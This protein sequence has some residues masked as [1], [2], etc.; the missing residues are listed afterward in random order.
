MDTQE[1]RRR[2]RNLGGFLALVEHEIHALSDQQVLSLRNKYSRVYQDMLNPP[3]LSPVICELNKS[4]LNNLH[5]NLLKDPSSYNPPCSEE[6]LTSPMASACR[7]QYPHVH[8]HRIHMKTYGLIDCLE[9][10]QS[11]TSM[12]P[13]ETG[14][15][16]KVVDLIVQYKEHSEWVTFLVTSIGQ[17]TIILGHMWLMEL[18][19]RNRLVHGRDQ[20]DW[21]A[22]YC[23]GQKPQ[24]REIGQ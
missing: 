23:A 22:W 17:T 16:T 15:I 4:C 13:H 3:S 19:P 18:Q 8:W 21:D 12:V 6:E 11:T 7:Q 24:R 20:Y 1:S 5:Y 9:K 10:S 14:H 2:Q